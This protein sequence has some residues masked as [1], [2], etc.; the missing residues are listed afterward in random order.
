MLELAVCGLWLVTFFFR[1]HRPGTENDMFAARLAAAL[2]PIRIG[3]WAVTVV[4]VPLWMQA[5]WQPVAHALFVP[6]LVA[7][8]IVQVLMLGHSGP[9]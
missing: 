8:G 2:R 5:S 3:T 6:S 1:I 7:G 4:S 9:L